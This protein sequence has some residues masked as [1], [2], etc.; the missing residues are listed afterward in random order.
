MANPIVHFEIIG[1]DASALRAFYN[2]LFGWNANTNSAVAPEVSAAGNY[3]FIQN[4]ADAGSGVPGGI[5]GGKGY[6][7]HAL[8]YVGVEDVD[9]ALHKAESLGGKRILGPAEKPG[10]GLFVGHFFDPEGNLIG[11]AGRQ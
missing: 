1:K 2:E 11:V 4:S 9:A 5:G 3:G 7:S 6:E 10:G 8:F